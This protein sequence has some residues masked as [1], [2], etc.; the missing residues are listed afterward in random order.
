[1]LLM[2]VCIIASAPLLNA[3]VL[4][5]KVGPLIPGYH[6]NRGQHYS[7]P[8]QG[9]NENPPT[10]GAPGGIGKP[11]KMERFGTISRGGGHQHDPRGHGPLDPL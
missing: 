3:G 7:F 4:V 1:M 5:V 8:Q 11:R 10:Q 9:E 6:R 2:R